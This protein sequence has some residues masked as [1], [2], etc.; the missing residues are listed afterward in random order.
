M[1][2]FRAG[3]LARNMNGRFQSTAVKNR[4]ENFLDSRKGK[5]INS[6]ADAIKVSFQSE[7][8]S[9][10]VLSGSLLLGS[11]CFPNSLLMVAIIVE[12]LYSCQTAGR[13]LYLDL[14]AFSILS[15]GKLSP[16]KARAR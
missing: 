14:A 3:K 5:S 15:R 10:T 1:T 2:T 6:R 13:K 16:T 9:D 7:C 12:V 8:E 4:T 11:V